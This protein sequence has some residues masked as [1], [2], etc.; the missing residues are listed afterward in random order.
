MPAA[1]G[2]VSTRQ[3][4]E[5]QVRLHNTFLIRPDLQA[6]KASRRVQSSPPSLCSASLPSAPQPAA[7]T[8]PSCWMPTLAARLAPI[9]HCLTLQFPQPRSPAP[10]GL[11]FGALPASVQSRDSSPL[12]DSSGNVST[13][14]GVGLQRLGTA[15]DQM[16]FVG[17][18][19]P[20]PEIT[21]NFLPTIG[22][23]GHW[24]GECKPCAF[25][26]KGCSIGLSCT[27]CHVCLP[28]ERIRRKKDRKKMF[29]LAFRIGASFP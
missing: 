22:S 25:V 19:P 7:S 26:D 14:G 16:D 11:V 21:P 27:F 1:V 23:E 8:V 20:P 2:V 17:N 28:S 29:K 24:R 9:P 12:S 15:S 6:R 3:F 5:Q 4:E 13:L 18:T 10:M